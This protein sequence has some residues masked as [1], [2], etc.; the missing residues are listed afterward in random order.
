MYDWVRLATV[1][2][3][4]VRLGKTGCDLV[5]MGTTGYNRVPLGKIVDEW[6]GTTIAL[7]PHTA[8]LRHIFCDAISVEFLQVKLNGLPHF[9]IV[10]KNQGGAK[11][12]VG[13]AGWVRLGTT[14]YDWLR[15][16]RIGYDWVRLG[17]IGYASVRLDAIS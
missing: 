10:G 4:R 8:V 12:G 6:V 2:N 17:T 1:G 11:R 9:G 13:C 16:G 15:L 7:L 14:R 3:D 5:G